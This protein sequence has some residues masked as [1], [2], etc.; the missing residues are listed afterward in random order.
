LLPAGTYF[1]TVEAAPFA[2]MANDSRGQ[3]D[4]RLVVSIR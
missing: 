1:P 4:D 2:Q 3:F